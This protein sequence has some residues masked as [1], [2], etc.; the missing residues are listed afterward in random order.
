MLP[1]IPQGL[2]PVTV[3]QDPARPRPDVQP[4]TPAQE[5]EANSGVK[6]DDRPHQDPQQQGHQRDEE[7]EQAAAEDEEVL[8]ASGKKAMSRKGLLVNLRV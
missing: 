8:T 3:Q 2:V 4:V 6:L 1:P 5:S 7:D